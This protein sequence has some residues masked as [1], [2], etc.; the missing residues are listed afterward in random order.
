MTFRGFLDF[1]GNM[2]LLARGDRPKVVNLTGREWGATV[3]GLSI[4]ARQEVK[5]D[6]AELPS[7]SVV[8]RNHGPSALAFTAPGW[9]AFYGLKVVG[10]NGA[11]VPLS[12]YGVQLLKSSRQTE[13]VEV[14][15]LPQAVSETILPVGSVYTMR[16]PGE[17]KVTVSCTLPDG[18]ALRSN[19]A[20][21][22]P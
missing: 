20:L 7:I 17:Y 11:E 16:G 1:V 2:G 21:V 22:V 6:S 4:S 9:L 10:P 14:S 8:L 15:L 5:Q 19:E 18:T 13:K 3:G 12:P